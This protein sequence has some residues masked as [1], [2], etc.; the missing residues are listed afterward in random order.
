MAAFNLEHEQRRLAEPGIPDADKIQSARDSL[1]TLVAERTHFPSFFELTVAADVVTSV[2]YQQRGDLDSS[3]EK[4][5][6]EASTEAVARRYGLENQGFSE[7]KRKLGELPLY[8]TVMFFSPPPDEQIPG[9]PGHSFAYF[10]HILPGE[11]EGKRTIKALAWTNWLSKND[12]AEILNGLN[13]ERT[14]SA[15]EGSILTSPVSS[16]RGQG[17]ES[18]RFLWNRVRDYL[19]TK[20]YTD[21][22]CPPSVVMQDYL[23][24]GER[25]MKGQHPELDIMIGNL[26]K[27]L[28]KG[29]GE[30]E[31]ADDFN[32]MLGRGDKDLLHKD[33]GHQETVHMN[34]PMRHMSEA[35]AVI[36]FQQNRD[37]GVNVRQV[38]SIL[39]FVGRNERF[40][41]IRFFRCN[42]FKQM[43]I[44]LGKYG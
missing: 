25:L 28:A 27:R 1:R 33:W 17:I 31:I 13:P 22:V 43:V 40:R 23:L 26:A 2:G 6:E 4:S 34:V 5:I 12:Q 38:M 8:S 44:Y 15:T 42:A 3:F 32:T 19:A 9:Y 35:E 10:Y 14:V 16:S 39:R 7:A 41:F 29:E 21:S 24:N 36:I 37:L 30:D 20:G 18:F 11:T